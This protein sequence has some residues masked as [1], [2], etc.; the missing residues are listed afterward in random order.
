MPI[1]DGSG[2][3]KYLC[4]LVNSSCLLVH[5]CSM[6][7]ASQVP[8]LI[9]CFIYL[10][11][12]IELW[13]NEESPPTPQLF[14]L[15]H[16]SK[17]VVAHIQHISDSELFHFFL[18]QDYI[19]V[20]ENMI[21]ILYPKNAKKAAPALC[22]NE[23]GENLRAAA[24]V[25]SRVLQ[26]SSVGPNAQTSCFFIHL[27]YYFSPWYFEE[28]RLY[29]ATW[30]STVPSAKKVGFLASTKVKLKYDCQGRPAYGAS[31]KFN[32]KSMT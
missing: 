19:H 23:L 14:R 11:L 13:H 16:V 27:K 22:S 12:V 7:I 24:T 9:C 3:R 30:R 20:L 32:R 2:E 5:T 26:G 8:S 15:E 17:D 6:F 29:N 1:S 28:H 10:E 31:G 25:H 18:S 4:S 21:L